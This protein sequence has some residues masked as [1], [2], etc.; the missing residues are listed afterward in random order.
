VRAERVVERYASFVIDPAVISHDSVW[1]AGIMIVGSLVVFF[2]TALGRMAWRAYLRRAGAGGIGAEAG[3]LYFLLMLTGSNIALYM[4][5]F[6]PS[7]A[8]SA[9]YPTMAWP[10]MAM[11][12]VLALKGRG[13][14]A[15]IAPCVFALVVLVGG[16]FCLRDTS[17]YN[18]VFGSP[19][20]LL[21]TRSRVVA[22]HVS[23]GWLPRVLWFCPDNTP[24]YAAPQSFLAY[25]SDAWLDGVI[26]GTLYVGLKA[27][28]ND[29][30]GAVA[31]ANKLVSRFEAKS[32]GRMFWDIG[33]G[34][35]VGDQH[36][37]GRFITPR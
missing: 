36:Q 14:K 23:H 16:A 10:Y 21:A 11:L 22:D 17:R 4:L 24:V 5:F 15:M 28:G 32:L 20:A 12:P 25:E 13:W 37:G 3:V 9:K 26:P 2:L 7:H 1:L 35:V 29:G 19:E 34:V 33:I 6:S 31:I 8:M 18:R 30:H 27:R